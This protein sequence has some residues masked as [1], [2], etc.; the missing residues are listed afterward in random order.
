MNRKNDAAAINA[1]DECI[2]KARATVARNQTPVVIF[3]LDH[4]L[5]DN[6]P[7]T[8]AIL[9]DFAKATGKYELLKSLESTSKY[10]LPYLI[11]D[12]LASMGF[13]DPELTREAFEWWKDRFFIDDWIHLDT[14]LPGATDFANVM[15][16]VGCTLVYLT[17]R[18]SPNMLVGTA[19]SLRT[20]GFPVGLAHTAMVLKPD[21]D[22]PD[23]DFKSDA[24]QF[25]SGLGTV[26]AAFDNE[27][28]NCN[29]FRE[30]YPDAVVGFLDTA[31]APNAPPLQ[32]HIVHLIDFDR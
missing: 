2:A 21:F 30:K 24:T 16:D 7:R 3:D 8:W 5:F 29:L 10:N 26:V 6:G 28:A 32:S 17:G 14:P 9:V 27:P 11:G 20:H 13:H 4:T 25:I 31:M 15:F 18:D 1:L 23:L 12:M 19:S 22:T